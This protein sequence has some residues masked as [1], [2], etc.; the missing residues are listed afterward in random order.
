MTV[1]ETQPETPTSFRDDDAFLLKM[2]PGKS[3]ATQELRTRVHRV[4]ANVSVIGFVLLVGEPGTGKNHVARVIA[5]HRRWL[6]VR[7]QPLET[8]EELDPGRAEPDGIAP[9]EEYTKRLGEKVLSEITETIAESQ[10]FGHV[11]GAFS[12]A[13]RDSPGLFGDDG[14]DDILLDEIG[15]AALALQAKLLAVLEGRA[16]IPVGGTSKERKAVTKRILMATNQDLPAMVLERTFR[17]DLFDR[18]RRHVIP[19]PALREHMEDLP[20][21]AAAIIRRICLKDPRRADNP[22]ALTPAD[23]EW[24]L[25]QTWPG[26]IRQLEELLENWITDRDGVPPPLRQIGARSH[27]G[28][29]APAAPRAADIP[30]LVRRR[31]DDILDGKAK[32]PGTFGGFVKDFTGDLGGAVEAAL[33][34]WYRERRPDPETMKRLFP[35]MKWSSLKSVMARAGRR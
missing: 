25:A 23:L 32:S 19:V 12:D 3:A 24:A 18:I 6:A 34:E 2:L 22:P 8:R 28:N 26:N 17:R 20:E 35:A 21:I 11:K 14:Y 13:R 4:N 7:P 33:Y 10:L 30:V 15:D 5:G 29:S 31:I 1:R 27:Y 9:L 16:F